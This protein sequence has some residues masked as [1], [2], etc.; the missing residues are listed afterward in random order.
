MVKAM[1]TYA[2]RF[3]ILLLMLLAYGTPR[4]AGQSLD[5]LVMHT[6]SF[7]DRQLRRTVAEVRDSTRFPRSTLPDGSWETTSAREWTS[8]FFPGCLWY[9]DE[10]TNDPFFKH[11]AERWTAG[12]ANEQFDSS[13]HDVGFEIFNSYG[14]GSRL[15]PSEAYKRVIVRAAQT[16]ASRFRPAVGCIK[17]W[18]NTRWQYPVIVDNMMNLELLFWAAAHGG[19][20]R[21]RNIAVSHAEKTMRNHFH[22]DGGTY[23]VLDYDTTDGKVIARNT[24]QGYTDESVW[25]RGQAWAI[26][27][28][29]M[30]YRF[31]K[32]SRFLNIAERAADY[33]LGHLPS[34]GVPY[35]D[36]QA[37]DIPNEPRDVSAAAIAASALFELSQYPES[38]STRNRYLHAAEKILRSLCSAPYLAEGT[39]SH[40]LLNHAVGSK[41]GNSEVDVSIIFAD[42]YFIEAMLRYL[43][44]GK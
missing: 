38:E 24:H 36:F 18:D 1:R 28:F 14:N 6:L 34:D 7:A 2:D 8:G 43:Q 42:Y 21:M 4:A 31:A 29:T 33:F 44:L 11:A 27:G 35:W 23:H 5:S 25:S 22:P 20:K 19:T 10:F 13:T 16:L 39:N 15:Y 12:M 9:M 37:P 32:D 3:G 41:P 26:Y 30:T 17:S 40:A